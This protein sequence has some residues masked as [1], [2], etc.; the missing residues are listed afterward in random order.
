MVSFKWFTHKKKDK[1]IVAVSTIT[2][3]FL[4]YNT[5]RAI[6]A[7]STLPTKDIGSSVTITVLFSSSLHSHQQTSSMS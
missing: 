6:E 7:V 4:W 2:F 5:I 3:F 1:V